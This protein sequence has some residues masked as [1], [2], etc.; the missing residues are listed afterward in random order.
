M[1]GAHLNILHVTFSYWSFYLLKYA[2]KCET[3]GTLN[4]NIKNAK[5]FGLQNASKKNYN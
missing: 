4:L 5:Q 1:W 2:M 3:H